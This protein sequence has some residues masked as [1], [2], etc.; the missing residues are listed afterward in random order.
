MNSANLVKQIYDFN[1]SY[2]LLA[3]KLISQDK[4]S[5]M[6]RL[7][8]D[9]SMADQLSE[10]SLPA[11]VKLSETNQLICKLRFI[12]G[13]VIQCLTRDSRVD[14]MQQIHTGIML[15]SDLLQ[16]VT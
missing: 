13:S 1:L 7:A 12:D 15:A 2:L 10:L 8:I 11:L 4:S 14:D 3:Q 16:S 9:E 5:A 6:F